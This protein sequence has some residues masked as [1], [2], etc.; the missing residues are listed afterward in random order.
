MWSPSDRAVGESR[1]SIEVYFDHVDLAASDDH[2]ALRISTAVLGLP[3]GRRDIWLMPR[4]VPS[5]CQAKRNAFPLPASPAI[6]GV[7]D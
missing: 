2:N 4:P 6:P 1:L 5:L 7:C 3:R